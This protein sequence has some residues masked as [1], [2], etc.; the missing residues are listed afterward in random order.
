MFEA[1]QVPE[2]QNLRLLDCNEAEYIGEWKT[3]KVSTSKGKQA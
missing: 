3:Q 2:L 1:P